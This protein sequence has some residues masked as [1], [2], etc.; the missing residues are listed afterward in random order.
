[1]GF[2]GIA[3]AQSGFSMSGGNEAVSGMSPDAGMPARIFVSQ[4]DKL[5]MVCG[6]MGP[7]IY[8]AYPR[9]ADQITHSYS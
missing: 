6:V 2:L 8:D 3:Q 9:T 7:K 4:H 5:L 1:M